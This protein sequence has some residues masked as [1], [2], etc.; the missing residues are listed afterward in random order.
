M[1]NLCIMSLYRSLITSIM[2]INIKLNKN[3]NVEDDLRELTTSL[4]SDYEGYSYVVLKISVTEQSWQKALTTISLSDVMRSLPINYSFVLWDSSITNSSYIQ[5]Q[6][7]AVDW[8]IGR[9]S[10]LLRL[11]LLPL[12]QLLQL[13]LPIFVTTYMH[14]TTPLIP[15]NLLHLHLS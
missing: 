2:I 15:P 11:Q 9:Y 3:N 8:P 1:N 14:S 10:L 13:L 5:L 7:I 4:R 6:Q 12:L